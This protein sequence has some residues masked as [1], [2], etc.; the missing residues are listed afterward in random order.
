MVVDVK[1]I[2]AKVREENAFVERIRE[3]VHRVIVG[4]QYMVDRLL[5]GLLANGHV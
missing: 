4:Q 3:Q 1:A 2:S 5:V